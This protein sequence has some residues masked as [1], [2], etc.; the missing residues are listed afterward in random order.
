[1]VRYAELISSAPCL[2]QK[3]FIFEFQTIYFT[4]SLNVS[5]RFSNLI[6]GRIAF[7]IPKNINKKLSKPLYWGNWKK[8]R[9]LKISNAPEMILILFDQIFIEPVK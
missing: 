8:L 2:A 3:Y 6:T 1:M 4:F 5:D 9:K 7:D